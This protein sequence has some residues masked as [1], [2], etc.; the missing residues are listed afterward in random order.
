MTWKA[1]LATWVEV[2]EDLVVETEASF[3][4]KSYTP[5]NSNMSSK[6]GLFRHE[7]SLPTIILKWMCVSFGG[8]NLSG[9]CVS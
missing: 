9:W 6:T 4:V 3:G 5:P 8:S 1:A 2:L 7:N